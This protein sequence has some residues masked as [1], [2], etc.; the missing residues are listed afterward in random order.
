M[1]EEGAV[2]SKSEG[3][4]CPEIPSRKPRAVRET[5]ALPTPSGSPRIPRFYAQKTSNSY[6][7]ASS[8]DRRRI[9][10]PSPKQHTCWLNKLVQAF[11]V[12]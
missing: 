9:R 7:T 11:P 1:K 8:M 5:E 2:R 10:T 12:G 3:L 4:G 6:F